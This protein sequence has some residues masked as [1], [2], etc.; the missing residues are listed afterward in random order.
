MHASIHLSG[1]IE[2]K[3]NSLLKSIG[4]DIVLNVMIFR[5]HIQFNKEQ[6][7][8]LNKEIYIHVGPP[9]TGTSAVQKWLSSN[10]SFLKEHGI[11]YPSHSVDINGVSSGNVRSIYDVD[12]AKKFTLNKDRLSKML[13]AFSV[14]EYSLLLLSSEFFFRRMDELKVHIPKAKFIAYVRNPMEVKE[15]NYNQ[16]VKRHFQ[17]EK[18]NATRSNRLP[19]MARLVEFTNTYGAQDV[20]LRLY[21]DNYFKRGNIVS[22]L[23]SVIGVDANVT[24]PIVNNSYQLEALEFKRWFN[25]FHL[26]DYQV[27]VDRALQGFIEG[28]SHY[29]LIAKEQY[30][31]DSSYYA[32]VLEN[33]AKALKTTNLAPLIA[34][35]KNASPK[36]YFIQALSDNHFLS[37]CLY[38]QGALQL[39]YYILTKKIRTLTPVQ[40]AH[41][42]HLFIASCN[43][44]FKY[45]YF[46]LKGPSQLPKVVKRFI[47]YTKSLG[48]PF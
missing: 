31:E 21:A 5:L 18:I 30:I 15:S 32:C 10:P 26:V 28:S 9:K 1:L 47:N 34:D 37:V 4:A 41:F 3:L 19:N 46:I 24:L 40:N 44:K 6:D 14:N 22:D 20:Y 39:D 16:S 8:E 48:R 2:I 45:L 27:M 13:D 43:R 17:L 12:K 7:V 33:Y 23:L 38:L 36:P 25:Q 11:Y 42:H 29:S 35:M